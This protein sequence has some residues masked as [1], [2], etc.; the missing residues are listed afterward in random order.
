MSWNYR[1]GYQTIDE[2][3]TVYGVVEAYYENG[4]VV[5]FTDFIEP[6]GEDEEGLKWSLERMLEA[7]AKPTIDI[8]NTPNT[9]K[10][11]SN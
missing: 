11:E 1:I 6:F 8:V 5:G 9:L 4:E 10:G 3:N 2:H 7:F